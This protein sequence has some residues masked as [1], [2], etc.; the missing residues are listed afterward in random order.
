MSTDVTTDNESPD[1]TPG[2]SAPVLSTRERLVPPLLDAAI[3]AVWFAVLGVVGGWVWAH[4]TSLPQVDKEGT[5]AT[6]AS[7]E[8]VKQVGMDGWFVIIALVGGV[9]SGVLLLVWRH[10]DPLLTVALVALG[11]GLASW[12]MIHAGGSFGPSDPIAALRKLPDGAHVSEQLRL[13]AHG[14]AWVWPIAASFGALLYLWVLKPSPEETSPEETGA[15]ET[16]GE[17]P[18]TDTLR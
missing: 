8:L 17:E 10:R 6:V 14:V 3:V 7:E 4:V 15:V 5:N 13:H 12:L 2:P 16:S 18:A 11:G 1:A 9:V